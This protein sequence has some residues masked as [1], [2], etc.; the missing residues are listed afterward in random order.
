MSGRINSDFTQDGN[1]IFENVYIHGELDYQ[2]DTIQGE[3]LIINKESWHGG[4][5]TFK[6]DV[7]IEGNLYLDYLTVNKEFDVGL[8][9]TVF[10]ANA[11]DYGSYVGVGTTGPVQ[12]FQVGFGTQG[13]VVSA[14][15]TVGIGTTN[16]YGGWTVD[17]SEYN[18]A[19]EIS[20]KVLYGGIPK[21]FMNI[22]FFKKTISFINDLWLEWSSKKC[23]HTYLFK[24]PIYAKNHIEMN[25]Q[26]LFNYYIQAYETEQ[27]I[28]IMNDIFK[29]LEGYNS[30]LVL[31]TYDSFLFDFNM[32]DGTNFM[33]DIKKAMK[34]SLKAQFGANYDDMKDVSDKI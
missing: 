33:R 20:F 14:G 3:K 15:G 9:G 1:S 29:V 32:K 4:I 26:K 31:Y 22:E 28:I 10:T 19:K 7:I 18:D 30:K 24:R 23:I 34:Y 11:D 2:F 12:K 16:P 17:N 21:E 25:K 13:F 8:G 27:N 6:D 5:A